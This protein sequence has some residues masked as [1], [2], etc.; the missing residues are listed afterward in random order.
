MEEKWNELQQI[1]IKNAQM[2]NELEE[3]KQ[4]K[5][6]LSNINDSSF[7][8]TKILESHKV[9]Q[10]CRTKV[11]PKTE[12]LNT[13][14]VKLKDFDY[15]NLITY[16]LINNKIYQAF[17]S[18]LRDFEPDYKRS[19][20]FQENPNFV[21]KQDVTLEYMLKYVANVKIERTVK[22]TVGFLKHIPGFAELPGEQFSKIVKRGIMD[23]QIITSAPMIRDGEFYIILSNGV[24]L[25]RYWLNKMRGKQKTDIKIEA[26]ESINR[27]SISDR[28]KA[29]LLVFLYSLPGISYHDSLLFEIFFLIPFCLY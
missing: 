12:Y 19:R 1:P 17:I 16:S 29:L 25:S 3:L 27:L 10:S 20:E 11:V 18:I 22:L 14:N 4:S 9:F 24:H 26:A 15:R 7:S 2:Q 28:E 8:L 6:F 21:T 13:F 5:I 23:F